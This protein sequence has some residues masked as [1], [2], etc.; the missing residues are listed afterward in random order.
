MDVER[1]RA[2]TPGCQDK[3]YLA[4]PGTALQSAGT[5]AAVRRHLAREIERTL[6]QHRHG[7]G[8]A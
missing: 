5:H 6:A 7:A 3:V 4:A 1:L 8:E 2:A